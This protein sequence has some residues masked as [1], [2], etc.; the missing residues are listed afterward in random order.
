MLEKDTSAIAYFNLTTFTAGEEDCIHR[1]LCAES[2][3]VHGIGTRRHNLCLVAFGN[4]LGYIIKTGVDNT[5]SQFG[6]NFG[7]AVNPPC[8]TNN[9]RLFC[10]PFDGFLD[11]F[12][13]SVVCKT[14]W[15]ESGSPSAFFNE[16][17]ILFSMD[18]IGYFY[19]NCRKN[20]LF[21]RYIKYYFLK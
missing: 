7:V 11:R 4:G 21:S 14:G 13:C 16:L 3:F 18:C 19:K 12:S 2:E 20:T 15:C 17:N 5:Q 9:D 8:H 1:Y 6:V 10:Q